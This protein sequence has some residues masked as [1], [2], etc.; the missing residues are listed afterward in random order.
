M[1]KQKFTIEKKFIISYK[2]EDGGKLTL[3][4]KKF[5]FNVN[6]YYKTYEI[7]TTLLKQ[8]KTLAINLVDFILLGFIQIDEFIKSKN[9][10]MVLEMFDF[11]KNMEFEEFKETIEIEKQFDLNYLSKCVNLFKMSCK[12]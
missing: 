11:V 1:E 4:I 7:H 2:I 8:E 5:K 12:I 3:G 10:T 9:I 6:D